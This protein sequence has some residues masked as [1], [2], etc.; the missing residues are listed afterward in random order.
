[1]KLKRKLLILIIVLGGNGGNL[2]N[3]LYLYRLLLKVNLRYSNPKSFYLGLLYFIIKAIIKN[4]F[5][6]VLR[7]LEVEGLLWVE[8]TK[9]TKQALSERFSS[10][11]SSLF[12][13][14]FEQLIETLNKKNRNQKLTGKWASVEQ[15]FNSV[16]IADAS[17]LEAIKKHLGQLQEK[18]G[19]YLVFSI[20]IARIWYRRI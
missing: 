3:S 2:F 19:N 20:D 11:P 14:L 18:T 9:V 4:D 7:M 10:L 1:L 8:Q 16:W 6:D 15:K 12:T 17:T 13:S 5:T